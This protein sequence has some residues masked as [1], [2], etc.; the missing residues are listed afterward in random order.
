MSPQRKGLSVKALRTLRGLLAATAVVG[1]LS[2]AG[3]AT[4]D[5]AAV[6]NGN[7]ITEKQAQTAA[8]QINK[9][10]QLTDPLTTTNAV[11]SLITAPF[12]N[13]V[14]AKAGK[15]ETDSSARA[16]MPNLDDPTPQT[17]ELVKA[18]FALQ[19]LT[20]QE[21]ADIVA[22]L[23]KAKIEVNPRYGTFNRK[24]AGIEPRNENWLEEQASK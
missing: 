15:A 18:N 1:T 3:C 5:T 2:V 23:Q 16:A 20:D 19:N 4:A 8:A 6:V 13:E 24:T 11:S 9:A 17:L 21:K 22:D 14:A 12:I 7:R 10:F